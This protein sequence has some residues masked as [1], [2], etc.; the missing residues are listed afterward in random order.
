[1]S[2]VD[3]DKNS[4]P[5]PLGELYL[6]KFHIYYNYAFTI[7]KDEYLA[8]DAVQNAFIIAIANKNEYEA[9]PNPMGWIMIALK[10]SIYDILRWKKKAS[11]E[12]S[13]AL[14]SEFSYKEDP[15][16]DVDIMYSD[17]LSQEDFRLLKLVVLDKYTLSQAAQE[18]G[19]SP[20]VC[21]KRIQRAKIR[22][23]DLL[24]R[25]E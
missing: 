11:A 9:S 15:A 7:L 2:K 3:I 20:Y 6:Q 4:S 16:H 18:F 22:L 25:Y 5:I 14:I 10:N 17:L 8:E 13:E 23:K 19:I 1:M 21:A 12:L 24:E